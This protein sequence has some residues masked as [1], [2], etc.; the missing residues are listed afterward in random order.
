VLGTLAASSREAELL[1][2][3]QLRHEDVLAC[4]AFA[5]KREKRLITSQVA[6]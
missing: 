2:C 4:L 6:A 1:E 3:P 5:A